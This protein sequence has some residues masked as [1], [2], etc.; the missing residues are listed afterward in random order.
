MHGGFILKSL[1]GSDYGPR[2][3]VGQLLNWRSGVTITPT[4]IGP[5]LIDFGRIGVAIGMFFIGL[6][7]GIGYKLLKISKNYFYIGLYLS[8]IHI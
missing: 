4:I 5:M 8:L 7:L 6:I 1:P 2:M 3:M